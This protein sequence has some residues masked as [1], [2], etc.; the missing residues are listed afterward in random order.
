MIKKR[1]ST[2]AQY[3]TVT[4]SNW[5]K[6]PPEVF[7]KTAVLKNCVIFTGKHLYGIFKNTYFK[8]HLCTA[9]SELALWNDCLELCFWIAFDSDITKIPAAFKY[10]YPLCFLVSLGFISSSLTVTTQKA[11]ACSPWTPC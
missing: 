1:R 11:N 3:W 10:I 6:Q 7:Y 4:L 8:E 9:A 2:D 5:K